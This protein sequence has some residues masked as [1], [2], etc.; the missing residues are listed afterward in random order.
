[1]ILVIIQKKE[2]EILCVQDGDK[3]KKMRKSNYIGY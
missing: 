1:M 3:W 2:L